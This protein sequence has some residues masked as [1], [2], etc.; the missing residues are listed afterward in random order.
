MKKLLFLTLLSNSLFAQTI[1]YSFSEEFD[2]IRGHENLGFYK[3]NSD[4]FC[5]IYFR[6]GQDIVFR[7]YDENFKIIE[8]EVSLNLPEGSEDFVNEGFYNLKSKFYWLYSV[9]NKISFEENL[10]AIQ[11]DNTTFKFLGV[12]LNIIRSQ[13]RLSAVRGKFENGKYIASKYEICYSQDSSKLLIV[14]RLHMGSI[15]KTCD[16]V[17]NG[18]LGYDIYDS[19]FRHTFGTEIEM[20]FNEKQM[21]ELDFEVDNKGNI[22]TLIEKRGKN[23]IVDQEDE[24]NAPYN[25]IVVNEKSKKTELIQLRLDN[26]FF[27]SI[28]LI[29]D[30]NNNIIV[31]GYYSKLKAKNGFKYSSDGAFLINIESNSN[32]EMKIVRK[33]YY[34]FSD[35]LVTMYETDKSKQNML[36]VQK[37][38]SLEVEQLSLIN[39]ELMSDSSLHII[40]SEFNSLN[41]NLFYSKSIYDM[42]ISKD[43][44]LVWSLK[45]PKSQ[46]GNSSSF[47]I[48]AHYHKINDEDLFFFIDNKENKVISPFESPANFDTAFDGELTCVTVSKDGKLSKKSIL[49]LKDKDYRIFPRNFITI[50]E[51]KVI[52]FKMQRGNETSKIFKLEIISVLND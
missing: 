12:P 38:N 1:N 22:Y 14:T 47:D 34:E 3:Y 48:L 32:N 39:L 40:G 45:I 18:I 20:P 13:K 7:A 6:K 33:K 10:Y 28:K 8:N 27:S 17:C 31:A 43:G 44:N 9:R 11:I 41:P 49:D 51:N 24:K 16:G 36:K 52:E 23:M 37:E 19:N 25:L 21:A 35:E 29:E 15:E 5:Q 46:R 2:V 42:K 26:Y 50:S 30:F 4:K